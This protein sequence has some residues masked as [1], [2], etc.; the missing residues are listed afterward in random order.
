M[1]IMETIERYQNELLTNRRI[2]YSR[3]PNTLHDE[4]YDPC[5]QNY[6]S[7]QPHK[8]TS[9]C[10]TNKSAFR[11]S[12]DSNNSNSHFSISQDSDIIDLF[13]HID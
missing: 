12:D 11:L 3:Y 6:S 2:N 7:Y 8:N 1:E 13:P 5:Q 4:E 10:S 9:G